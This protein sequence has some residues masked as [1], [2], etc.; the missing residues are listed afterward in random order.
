VR[1]AEGS[2]PGRADGCL[3]E[4]QRIVEQIRARWSRVHIILR[5]DSG[6]CRDD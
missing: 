5:G 3:A 6:F 2:R 4:V 1:A